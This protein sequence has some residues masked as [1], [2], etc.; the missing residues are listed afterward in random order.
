MH[1]QPHIRVLIRLLYASTCFEHYVL[2]IRRSKF[3]H[4]ASGTTTP[5]GGRHVHR[6]TE[7]SLNLRTGR[8]PTGATMTPDAA[9]HNPDLLLMMMMM[10]MMIIIIIII[11]I[12]MPDRNIL[13]EK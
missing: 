4:T 8:P 13:R 10:M 9:Q 3:D 6:L 7:D 11:I 1:G 2:I 12:I 5:A